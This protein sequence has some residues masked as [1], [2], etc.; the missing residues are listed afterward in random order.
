MNESEL[1]KQS[2]ERWGIPA[3]ILMLAEESAEL[4]VASLHMTRESRKDDP[5]TFEEFA[6]E[7]ADVE[8]MITEMKI[9]FPE[10]QTKLDYYHKIKSK[11]TEEKLAKGAKL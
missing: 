7:I 5:K 1:I 10:L 6:E 8:F 3:Q 4:S 11:R 2:I 9:V